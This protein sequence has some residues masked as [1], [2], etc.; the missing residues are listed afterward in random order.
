MLHTRNVVHL[1]YPWLFLS[2]SEKQNMPSSCCR[3]AQKQANRHPVR[4]G[5]NLP[6]GQLEKA[7]DLPNL[8]RIGA[9][10][11]GVTPFLLHAAFRPLGNTALSLTR[12]S[13]VD[14]TSSLVRR[15]DGGANH[16]TKNMKSS[17]PQ[18]KG[19]TACSHYAAWC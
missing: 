14:L 13:W 9:T 6:V 19:H 7:T 18:K 1:Y 11:E 15:P 17:R 12:L 8:L 5:R 16:E 2:T 3:R 4:N 10:V